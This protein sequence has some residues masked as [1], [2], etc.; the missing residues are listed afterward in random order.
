M[1]TIHYA[2]WFR[3]PGSEMMLFLANY[4]GSWQSYLEDFITKA[5]EGQSSV[6]SHGRGFPKNRLLVL[7]GAADGDRFKR[8][9]RRQQ[10]VTQFWYSRSP[11]LTTKQIRTNAMI[12]DG[13]MR[14]QTDTAARAWLDCFG[15]T[16]RPAKCVEA[17]EVQSLVFR[18]LP[19]HDFMLCAALHLRPTRP[20]RSEN[21]G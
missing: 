18:G 7:H 11:E 16:P 17:D 8:W 19:S 3:L 1:G 6:W 9:V 10:I 13:L 5:H 21:S 12:H 15:T 2:R 14:A 4:D 20:G